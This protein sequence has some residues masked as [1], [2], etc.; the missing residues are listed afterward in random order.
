MK[1][2]VKVSNGRV[3][4]FI[5]GSEYPFLSGEVD[6]INRLGYRV[7]E[8]YGI[9]GDDPQGGPFYRFELWNYGGCCEEIQSRLAESLAKS[10]YRPTETTSDGTRWA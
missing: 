3:T 5:H 2:L 9:F 4:L 7:R 10:P 8:P 6:A 1:S